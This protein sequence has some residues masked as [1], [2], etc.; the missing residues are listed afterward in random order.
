MTSVDEGR[1]GIISNAKEYLI[2]HYTAMQ[3]HEIWKQLPEYLR[4]DEDLHL[5][6][7]CFEHFSNHGGDDD[8]DGPPP[9]KFRCILCRLKMKNPR[10]N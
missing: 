5:R 6:L 10:I 1:N 7:P 8:F 4:N 3:L 9:P 2:E